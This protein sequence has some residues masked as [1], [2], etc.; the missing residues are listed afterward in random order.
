M[1]SNEVLVK[2]LDELQVSEPK[3]IFEKL[4]SILRLEEPSFY[5]ENFYELFWI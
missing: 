3:S 5:V 4:K 2:A 1:L